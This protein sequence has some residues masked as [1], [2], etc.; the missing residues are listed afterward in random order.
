MP[1]SWCGVEVGTDE[2]FRAAEPEGERKAAFCRLEHVVP[3]AIQ[4]AHWE[5]GTI[6]QPG[7]PDDGLGAARTAAARWATAASCSCATAASTASPTPSAA[8]TTCCS[9]RRPGALADAEL[10]ASVVRAA[11]R[12]CAAHCLTEGHGGRGG[13]HRLDACGRH[14]FAHRARADVRRTPSMSWHRIAR[15]ARGRSGA[16]ARTVARPATAMTP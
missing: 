16:Y 9:G 1:C 7:E 15:S 11:L 12:R 14:G 5:P 8:S 3:W 6:L 4:G 2:G 13:L 10:A